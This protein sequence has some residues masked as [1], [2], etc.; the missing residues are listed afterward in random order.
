[1]WASGRLIIDACPAQLGSGNSRGMTS[2]SKGWILFSD[3]TRPVCILA[4]PKVFFSVVL[5]IAIDTRDCRNTENSPSSTARSKKA[6]SVRLPSLSR[7]FLFLSNRV[8]IS[9]H[10]I[11]DSREGAIV[12]KPIQVSKERSSRKIWD[13][14]ITSSILP[15]QVPLFVF[16]A[17]NYRSQLTLSISPT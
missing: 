1:L 11:S 9:L 4:A 13:R 14:A 17:C 10:V 3:L 8:R 7:S 12:G 15:I 6:S 5:Q 2:I 16:I